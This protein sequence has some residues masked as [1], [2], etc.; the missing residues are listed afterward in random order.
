MFSDTRNKNVLQF[1]VISAKKIKS[2][3]NLF[4]LDLLKKI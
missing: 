2:I 3:K 1:T 4:F